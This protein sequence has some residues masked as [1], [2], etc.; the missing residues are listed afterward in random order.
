MIQSN[1]AAG[2]KQYFDEC[3]SREGY[4]DQDKSI[5]GQGGAKRVKLKKKRRSRAH[6][7]LS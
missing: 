5:V 6:F 7:Y 3:L 2:A 1:N 4:Y